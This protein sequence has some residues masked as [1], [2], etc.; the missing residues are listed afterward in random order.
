MCH[1]SPA[2]RDHLH[3]PIRL[4]L[5]NVSASPRRNWRGTS[6]SD[7]AADRRRRLVA[8]GFDLFGTDGYARTS[9][10]ALCS[11][12]GLSL[13]SFYEVVHDREELMRLVWDDVVADTLRRVRAELATQPPDFEVRVPVGLA[14]YVDHMT[15]DP[16][17]ARIVH[18]SGVGLSPGLEK[19]RRRAIHAFADVIVEQVAVQM[20]ARPAN[21]A[22]AGTRA[23]VQPED[24]AMLALATVGGVNELLVDWLLREDEVDPRQIITEA[25]SLLLGAVAHRFG[26]GGR[27]MDLREASA[28]SVVSHR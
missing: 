3:G 8:A 1:A 26:G 21:P 13:R 18:L 17:R 10:D 7:R 2:C 12:A 27:V 14:A 11:H 23:Q 22:R 16:R 5:R 19:H 6:A 25:T 24:F 9:I 28:T 20:A 4:T 15:E